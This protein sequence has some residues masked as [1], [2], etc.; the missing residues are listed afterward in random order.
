MRKERTSYG[1]TITEHDD[2]TVEIVDG[3]TAITRSPEGRVTTEGRNQMHFWPVS[4]LFRRIAEGRSERRSNELKG[5]SP[6]DC[7]LSR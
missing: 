4:D 5:A 1:P 3:A 7:S 6:K 2:G